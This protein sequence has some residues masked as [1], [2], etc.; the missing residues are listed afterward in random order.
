MRRTTQTHPTRGVLGV[1]GNFGGILSAF[2]GLFMNDG[3]IVPHTPYSKTGID[4]VPAMLTPGELVVPADKVKSFNEMNKQS[5][6]TVV[7]LSVTGDVS[8][9]TRKEIASMLPQIASGVNAQN[10]ENNYRY[11]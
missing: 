3:G 1:F 4:S 8:R 2:S 6:Q 10:K 11:R 7:N 9:Q 5:T